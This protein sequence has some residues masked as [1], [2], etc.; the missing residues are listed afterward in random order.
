VI[1]SFERSKLKPDTCVAAKVNEKEVV[2]TDSASTEEV[3]E[4]ALKLEMKLMA[5]ID[6]ARLEMRQR[7]KRERERELKALRKEAKQL[8][9]DLNRL[10]MTD[11]DRVRE[12]VQVVKFAHKYFPYDPLHNGVLHITR[13]LQN[14]CAQSCFL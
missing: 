11:V 13:M 10:Q 7:T 8:G 1:D 2:P 9:I 3:L 5:E 14:K 12:A 4:R 6:A